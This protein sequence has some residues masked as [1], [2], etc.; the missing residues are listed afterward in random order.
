M[1]NTTLTTAGGTYTFDVTVGS[2][3]AIGINGTF[4]GSD[5]LL[6]HA[7]A[8]TPTVFGALAAPKSGAQSLVWDATGSKLRVTLRAPIFAAASVN[9]EVTA[10]T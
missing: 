7:N 2:S 4:G 5:I 9:I 6:E 1:A 8:A 3:Y 10:L